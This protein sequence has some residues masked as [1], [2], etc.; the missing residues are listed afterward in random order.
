MER[1]IRANKEP[2]QCALEQSLPSLRAGPLVRARCEGAVAGRSPTGTLYRRLCDL[3]PISLGRHPRTGRLASAV[4]KVRPYSRADQDQIGRVWSVRAETRGQTRQKP[5]GNYLLPGPH[6][7]LHAEPK[8]KLQGWD[9]HREISAKAQPYVSARA[10]AANT[11]SRHQCT[12]RRNQRRS[13]RP[14]CLLRRRRKSSEPRQSI[15]GRG[16]LLAPDVV[17]PQLGRTPPH[18]G[19]LQPNQRTDTVTAT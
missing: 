18:L 2:D 11:T 16:A 1:S 3:L 6:P 10:N 17:Q 15:S 9:A 7:V 8:R 4:G 19:R 13:T 14:L 5:P 12:D